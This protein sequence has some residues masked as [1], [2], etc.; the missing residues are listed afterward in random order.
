MNPSMASFHLGPNGGMRGALNHSDDPVEF[1]LR[2]TGIATLD[3]ACEEGFV[4][5]ILGLTSLSEVV[6]GI[7][8]QHLVDGVVR[9]NECDA[10]GRSQR[11][12][13]KRVDDSR[14]D[15]Y[16]LRML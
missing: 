7:E 5:R 13:F 2:G 16:K 9:S 11:L 15:I 4:P 12:K 6:A 8:I 14:D 10:A 3:V 1:G